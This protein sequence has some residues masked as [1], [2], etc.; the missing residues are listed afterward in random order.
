[1]NKRIKRL[2][3]KFFHLLGLP[4]CGGCGKKKAIFGFHGYDNE[5]IFVCKKCEW[6]R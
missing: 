4:Y 3:G 2:L 1:M 6:D 5:P